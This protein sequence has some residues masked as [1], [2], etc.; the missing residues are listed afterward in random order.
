LYT[1]IQILATA[2][3]RRH[4]HDSGENDVT[5]IDLPPSVCSCAL[6]QQDTD[7]LHA[8]HL[9]RIKREDDP[10]PTYDMAMA[11]FRHDHHSSLHLV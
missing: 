10:P 7:A 3:H 2:H 9:H 8:I 4:G 5:F 6:Q 1:T 11:Y